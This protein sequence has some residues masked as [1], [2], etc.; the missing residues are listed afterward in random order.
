M[1]SPLNLILDLDGTLLHTEFSPDAVAIP[2]RTRNSYLAISTITALAR[3]SRRF[4]VVL[5]TGRSMAA[6]NPITCAMKERNVIIGGLVLEDGA[7]VGS[8]NGLVPLRPG[9]DLEAMRTTVDSARTND[10]PAFE[11]QWDF[12]ACLVARAAGADESG[13]LAGLISGAALSIFPDL[14]C[15]RDGRKVYLM[16]RLTH[17]WAGLK[18]LLGEDAARSVGVGDGCNDLCW[19]SMIADPITL[20]GAAPEVMAAVNAAG[21]WISPLDQHAG[22]LHI[23]EAISDYAEDDTWPGG[24]GSFE[25]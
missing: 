8:E 5:A 18:A 4:R 11:W 15:A 19:L 23:L 2:G 24:R 12:H 21:G 9:G 13:A 1:D 7:L 22:I 17:K 14:R 16:H 10:W 6:A 20:A 3:L 25:P